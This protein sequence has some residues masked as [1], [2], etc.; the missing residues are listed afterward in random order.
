MRASPQFCLLGRGASSRR[1]AH[2]HTN[3]HTI[4]D[5]TTTTPAGRDVDALLADLLGSS[6]EDEGG[7][8]GASALESTPM[9]VAA[10]AATP[11]PPRA[12]VPAAADG[13]APV[14]TPA[15]PDLIS[16]APAERAPAPPPAPPPASAQPPSPS[17]SPAAWATPAAEPSA[18]WASP[19]PAA[20]GTDLFYTPAGGGV[21]ES[22]QVRLGG[23]SSSPPPPPDLA[24]GRGTSAGADGDDDEEEEDLTSAPALDAAEEAERVRAAGVA[25]Q[26]RGAGGEEE[27][28]ASPS[29][30][31][32]TAF[33]SGDA[34]VD[35]PPAP[36]GGSGASDSTPPPSLGSAGLLASHPADPYLAGG[37]LPLPS[38]GPPPT[39]T[40]LASF[41]AVTAVGTSAGSILVIMPRL[42][43]PN[44]D[45]TERAAGGHVGPLVH[46][47]GEEG[48]PGGGGGPPISPHHP[49]PA[50]V[51]ALAFSPAGTL[52]AAGHADGDVSFWEL[53][54]RAGW[55]CV[56]AV[57]DAHV[58]PV[59]GL[60]WAE[61]PGSAAGGGG[62]GGGGVGGGRGRGGGGGCG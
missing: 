24:A 26:V 14:S 32:A 4:G 20:P 50:A 31:A 46:R 40:A 57:R 55:A 41:H 42:G 29:A 21:D 61:V 58:S 5:A 17:P 35:A 44:P 62:V 53:R 7:G 39:I 27:V 16:P 59:T 23:A 52:L 37:A 36:R 48:V 43:L 49:P 10:P 12:D 22:R 6:S 15:P 13:S 19:S 30:A 9:P 60:A 45:G 28:P 51:T 54:G 11:S 33:L 56:R 38:L 25:G 47:L 3:T 1:P 34:F 8:G 18:R 2:T